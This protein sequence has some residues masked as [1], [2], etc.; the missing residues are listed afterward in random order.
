VCS[1]AMWQLF[2]MRE[3]QERVSAGRMTWKGS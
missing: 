2:M 1:L 3:V